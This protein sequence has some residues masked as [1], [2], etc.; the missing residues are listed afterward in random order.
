MKKPIPFGKYVLLERINVG[1]MAEVFKAKAFGVEGFE[2]LVAV[3]RI[4][5]SIAEDQEFITMFIDEAKIAVQLTH[6]NIA[7]IFDLGKVG[8]SF[9]IAMEYVHGKDLRAIF[10]RARKR[11]ET[12]PVPMACYTVMKVCEGLDY[13]HN[14]KDAAGRGLNLVHRDVSP[15]NI[16]I[17]YDGETKIIDFGIAKAA[18]KAGKTQ[19]GIL[20]GKF[21][22]MSP[23]QVRGLPLDRRSDIFAVGIVL[24][25]LLTGERLFVGESDFSTLEKVRNVEIMPPS[26]YNRRIPEELEQ[27]I[28]KAL[29][30]D[31]D[32]RYQTAMDLHD[33]L[34][35]FMYTSGNFFSRKDLSGYMRKAFAEE[36]AKE[37]QREEEYRQMEAAVAAEQGGSGGSG[38]DA[39][40]DLEPAPA[41]AA[42][43]SAAKPPAPPA[44]PAPP[45][46]KPKRT[47]MGMGAVPPP[48][49]RSSGPPPPPPPR[50]SGGPPQPQQVSAPPQPPPQ[51]PAPQPSA[52]AALDMD[53]DDEELSTQIYDKPEDGSIPSL[54]ELDQ[55]MGQ[56]SAPQPYQPS[57]APAAG[58]VPSSPGGP[59][60]SFTSPSSAPGA[61]GVPGA[62]SPFEDL[63]AEAP[64]PSAQPP[65]R[66]P[67]EVTRQP[68]EKGGGGAMAAVV[69]L[70]AVLLVAGVGGGLGWWF[71]FRT[72]PATINVTT[73]PADAVVYLDNEPVTTSTSSPFVL[74]GIEPGDHLVEVRKH[75]FQTWATRVNL[76]SGQTL[77]LPAVQLTP[78]GG[79]AGGTP[80]AAGGSP[81]AG[82]EGTGFRLDTTPSGAT[83]FVDDEQRDETTPVTITDLEPG[84]HTIRAELDNYAPYTAQITVEADQVQQ[85]PTA[86]LTLR[87]VSVRFTSEPSGADVLLRRGGE[88]REIGET[89]V[90][91][92][93]DTSGGQWTVEMSR[94]GYDDWEEPLTP[95][96]GQAEHTVSATLEE[97]RIARGRGRSRGRSGGGTS[98]SSGGGTSSSGGGTS[99]SGGTATSGAPG[100]LR[101]NTTPWSEVYVDGRRIG[102]TPQMNIRLPAGRHTVTL[103]NPDFNIRERVQ[104]NIAPGGTETLIRRLTPGG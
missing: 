47:M 7:Q 99:S 59:A 41:K 82:V 51:P 38:L 85:L 87:Q 95:P 63:P 70:L 10:D 15:Q 45:R 57:P 91:A 66:E 19:A 73:T 101:V 18:G 96:A 65:A 52:G 93:V 12:V 58:P 9:F 44:P 36:I 34:Q 23:E 1:G 11:G 92:R 98:T 28:L 42:N 39:F 13:A 100:T 62:P 89:P 56:A 30:K 69:A 50:P 49:P 43:I 72:E 40:A 88:T 64:Q 26:T 90:T 68:K 8:E 53:W 4:L 55:E 3:K 46:G 83:V 94:R 37:S 31:V 24:Y 97:R 86:V 79:A 48:P 81:V 20:K 84:T 77:E 74:A 2:R 32:D 27:I 80:E 75:G 67:T 78:E 17:S 103:V 102:N 25:E 29:A 22:Y 61:P 16:L 33:D 54:P 21:G 5:P 14:K 6:A 76:S 35:S 104:V 71:F 60:P